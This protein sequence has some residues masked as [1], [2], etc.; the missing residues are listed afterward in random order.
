M[1]KEMAVIKANISCETCGWELL[2]DDH[3]KVV[4]CQNQ[5]CMI[6]GKFKQIK[7]KYHMHIP[8]R[9]KQ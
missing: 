4:F 3:T 2:V 9:R 6:N 5:K 7:P 8:E 1:E